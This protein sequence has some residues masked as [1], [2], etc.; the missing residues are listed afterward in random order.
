MMGK[1]IKNKRMVVLLATTV[2]TTVMSNGIGHKAAFAQSTTQTYQFNIPAKPIHQAMNDIVRIT[3]IDVVLPGS[4]AASAMGKPVR[5][6]LTSQ[7]ALARL[8]SGS[9][10]NYRF[11]GANTVSIFDQSSDA[12]AT[13]GNTIVLDTITVTGNKGPTVGWDGSQAS[14]YSTPDSVNYISQETL[15]RYPGQNVGDMFRGTPGVLSAE[16]RNSAALDV[17]IRGLQGMNRVPV[18]VDGAMNQTSVYRGYQ[19]M[20]GRSYVDPD[21]IGGVSIEKG[22]TNGPGLSGIGG[23]VSMRTINADDIVSEGKQ[24]GIR[25]KGEATSNNTTPEIGKVDGWRGSWLRGYTPVNEDVDRPSLLNFGGGSGSVVAGFK[26]EF[27]DVVGGFARRKTGNYHAG[28]HGPT[29]D[30]VNNGPWTDPYS[31]RVYPN[32]YENMGL[33]LYQGGQEVL[34][35]SQDVTSGLLKGT[36]RFWDDHVLELGFMAYQNNHGEVTPWNYTDNTPSLVT[37]EELSSTKLTTYTARYNWNPDDHDLVNLKWNTWASNLK[38]VRPNWDSSLQ[39]YGIEFG[40][41][42]FSWGTDISNTSLFDTQAGALTFEYGMG[43]N[44]EDSKPTDK[45]VTSEYMPR[46]GKRYEFN[47]FARA[48]LEITDQWTVSGGLRYQY[49]KTEDRYRRILRNTVEFLPDGS[50]SITPV[51][52]DPA[53]SKSG[54]GVSPSIGIA[55][56]P[57]EGI[58]LF[59]NYKQGLRMPSLVEATRAMGY[60]ILPDVDPERAHNREIGFNIDRS[61]LFANGDS[62]GLKVAYFNNRVDNYLARRLSTLNDPERPGYSLGLVI[63]NIKAAKFSGL[64][65]SA[66]YRIDNTIIGLSGNYFHN[67]EFCTSEDGCMEKT[68]SGDFANNQI[69]PKY[70][71]SLDVSQKLFDDT[72][73]VGGRVTHYGKRAIL[74]S[75]DL[76]GAMTIIKPINWKAFT[77]VDVFAQYDFN[78]NLAINLSVDNLTDQYYVDPLSLGNMPAPGRTVRAGVTAKF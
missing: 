74:G 32:Y 17:N 7:E 36:F 20:A 4:S 21:F 10:L 18:T 30:I 67:V 55:Y 47:S 25:L 13:G 73:T 15:E 50:V 63:D 1:A 29:A 19:G 14:V 48:K 16:N 2:L 49:F 70:M 75:S 28:K 69:P 37:Q 72:L 34:N 78:E 52:G 46:D 61:S 11:T 51:Y 66:Q 42:T 24:F 8:L 40:S 35:T 33:T 64:E 26:S 57:W 71:V 53:P 62:F 44:S 65:A 9:N 6:A 54:G 43:Y 23:A 5:G 39:S 58:Q 77:T 68:L 76:S 31:G 38:D 60:G 12:S 56:E 41:K 59:A 3:G 45:E 27:V 22:P